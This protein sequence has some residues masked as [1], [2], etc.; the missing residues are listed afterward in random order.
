[1][2]NKRYVPTGN[3]KYTLRNLLDPFEP[4]RDGWVSMTNVEA[5]RG[6][7]GLGPDNVDFAA[8]LA[9]LVQ[10]GRAEQDNDR[11]RLT[12]RGRTIAGRTGPT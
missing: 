5:Q 9:E 3:A 7:P 12:D 8:G 11:Y 2:N 4:D 1:M 10:E 6:G